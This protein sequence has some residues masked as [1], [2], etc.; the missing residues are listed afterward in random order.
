MSAKEAVRSRF[1]DALAYH[2]PGT[3]TVYAAKHGNLTGINL[4]SGKT[5][6]QAWADART[7]WIKP[8]EQP[9]E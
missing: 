2:W 1:P 4:G 3:W 7:K 8:Q 5:A 6:A 9:H